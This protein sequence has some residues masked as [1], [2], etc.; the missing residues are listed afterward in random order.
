MRL[1][2]FSVIL[3][4]VV[5]VVIGVGIT[6]LL[7][8]QYTPTEKRNNLNISFSWADASARVIEAEV[9]SK[10]EG[11]ISSVSGVININ[12][13]SSK[14]RGSISVELK[15]KANIDAIKYEIATLIRRVYPK[16]PE[17]VSYPSISASSSSPDEV[18][19]PILYYTIN[20]NLP[21][22]KIKDYAENNILK[23]IALIK[24]VGNVTLSGAT[25]YYM[26]ISFDPDVI[27]AQGISPN[28]ISSAINTY[29]GKSEIIGSLNGETIILKTESGENSL[30]QVPVKNSAG[31]IIRLDELTRIEYKEKSPDNYNR[32][33]GLN[34]INLRITAE[35][36]VNTIEV[37]NAVK[38][39]MALL[40]SHFPEKFS[41][42]ITYDS[43]IELKAELTKIIRRTV[44]SILILLLFVFI[45]S[46]SFR[47]LAIIT[48]TLAAN[49]FISFIFYYLFDLQIHIYSLAGITVSLGII[50]DTSIIM[51]SHYG[52]YRNRKVFIAILAALLTTIGALA[53]IFFL[54]DQLKKN[55]T[56]FSAVII[57]NLS[58]SLAIALLF[59]PALID[60]FPVKGL[61]GKQRFSGRR[62]II[63][64]NHLYSRYIHFGVNH[65]WIF[66]LV[67]LLGFGIPINLLPL[68][69]KNEDNFLEKIYNKTVGSQFYQN[70]IK[71]IA[72]KTLGGSLRLF[73]TNLRGGGYFGEP[74]RTTLSIRASL[75]QGCTI[76][77]L[78]EIVVSMENFLSQ[79]PQIDIFNTQISSASNASISVT[80]KKAF[81][82][83]SFPLMLKSEV[84]AKA[85]DF[86]GANWQV[87]GID[88]NG[89]SNNVGGFSY[90]PN[91]ISITGYNYD[92][93]Y[94]FCQ[95]SIASLALNQRVTGLEI[96]GD[97]GWERTESRNE[98]FIDF[99]LEHMSTIGITPNEAYSALN[100]QLFT[101]GAS[102]YF[103]GKER[104]D[105]EIVSNKKKDYDIWHLKNSHLIIGNQPIIFSEIGKINLKNSGNNIYKK[106]QQYSLSVAYDFI[107]PTELSRRVIKRETERLNSE[108]L[109]VGFRAGFEGSYWNYNSSTYFWLL[110]IIIAI[111]Y[112]ICAILFESLI[113]P[114]AI[115]LLIPISFIGL[116]LTF[117]ITGFNFDQGGFAALIMLSGIS[118]NAGIYIMN[119]FNL[120]RKSA[121][122]SR[123]VVSDFIKA[124]NHKII[125]IM[126]TILS[127]I[128]GLTPFLFD[129]K[130]EVFWFSFAVGTMG[131]LIFS[132][133]GIIL[134][135]PIW[136]F[137][138]INA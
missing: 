3:I 27:K 135:L 23:E 136:K 69:I 35:K 63:S 55:L 85:I 138:N 10:L 7:N 112:F 106:N 89:F 68:N 58:V 76:Q 133:I 117:Y 70:H 97:N 100:E 8:I 77:Q 24:G 19:S 46:R 87:Y 86:G 132:I 5:M 1:P 47:Y 15:P 99:D 113:Q 101:S 28:E 45:A 81:D 75:P 17:K 53:V 130:N 129:G 111:I 22:N 18:G 65:K 57:I 84:I 66:L 122:N 88:E 90:K 13:V 124:Y 71:Q 6:P 20:A 21:T 72:E 2:P 25:P 67:L 40:S 34:T 14:G 105:L 9:T 82:N 110:F 116:F 78:N 51:I 79:F 73:L 93:L 11:V 95:E 52:Y 50:I 60:S 137:R 80:F 114:L 29:I 54:P 31:R 56:E 102:G 83:G 37:C 94:K 98:Y 103:D 134:F 128:L 59:V 119:Q 109:P 12:S 49:I 62:K 125:P 127:T 36:S 39:K 30:A 43:S 115:I 16:L 33:N 32:I 121:I 131:G 108:V 38:E 126:L 107:G 91:R 42:K 92:L 104:V 74:Q 64:F 41:A 96:S 26:E 118:V 123:S 4:F 61:R 44:L 120:L 48:V